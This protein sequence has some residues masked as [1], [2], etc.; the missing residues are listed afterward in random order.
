MVKYCTNFRENL[1]SSAAV[2]FR[3][4]CAHRVD[5]LEAHLVSTSTSFENV[6]EQ[7]KRL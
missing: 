4:A 5:A 3:D 7:N 1:H 6:E 2:F